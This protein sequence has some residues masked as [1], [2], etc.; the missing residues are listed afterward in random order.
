MPS[1]RIEAEHLPE[2]RRLIE[3]EDAQ[4]TVTFDLREVKLLDRDAVNFLADCE[5]ARR[6]AGELPCLCPRVDRQR[7]RENQGLAAQDSHAPESRALTSAR[8][9]RDVIT[10]S[11]EH[12]RQ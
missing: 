12:R 5:A 11:T 10:G 1:G 7:A 2:L 9:D 8:G 6:D 3:G 4:R